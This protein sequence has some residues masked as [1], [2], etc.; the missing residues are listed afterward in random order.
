MDAKT[1]ERFDELVDELYFIN[2]NRVHKGEVATNDPRVHARAIVDYL[3]L[4]PEAFRMRTQL[5]GLLELGILTRL[6]ARCET[7]ASDDDG[8]WGIVPEEIV[9]GGKVMGANLTEGANGRNL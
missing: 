9:V 3:L 8:R 7:F 1:V 6:D 4:A 5:A 2:L